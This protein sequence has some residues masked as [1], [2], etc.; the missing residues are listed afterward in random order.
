MRTRLQA[1]DRV[2]QRNNLYLTVAPTTTLNG[3]DHRFK[4]AEGSDPVRNVL[5][6][7]IDC[8]ALLLDF[9]Q[10]SSYF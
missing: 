5:Y 2:A 10:Y 1:S 4:F 3:A 9:V 7:V 6:A 8:N